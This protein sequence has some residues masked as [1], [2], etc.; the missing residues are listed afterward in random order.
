MCIKRRTCKDLPEPTMQSQYLLA[1]YC[2]IAN[3]F[4]PLALLPSITLPLP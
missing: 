1:K 2:S 3:N 4:H